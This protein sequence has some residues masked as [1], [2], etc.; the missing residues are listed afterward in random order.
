[1][2]FHTDKYK[3]LR[4]TNKLQ[5]MEASYY[6]HN[7]K[8]DIV[9]TGKYLGV[10]LNKKLSWKPHVGTICKKANQ[11]RVFLRRN[12]KDCQPDVKSQCYKTCAPP[13]VE[14]ASVVW[15]PVG[16]G[17]QHLR[18]QIE[19]VQRHAARFVTGDW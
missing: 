19:M 5:P 9:E 8:L 3:L 14:Y 13:I 11:T 12:L 6:M 16:E 7:N 15:D 2:E 17:N 18:Y 10:L 4:I 1:M